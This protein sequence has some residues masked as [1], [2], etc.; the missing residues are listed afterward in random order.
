MR[1]LFRVLSDSMS[2]RHSRKSMP[3]KDHLQEYL[4]SIFPSMDQLSSST[5]L[6]M[7]FCITLR[8]MER[9]KNQAWRNT[10]T[11][12]GLLGISHSDGQ[13]KEYGRLVQAEMISTQSIGHLQEMVRTSTTIN[14]FQFDK[15][16][17]SSYWFVFVFFSHCDSWWFQ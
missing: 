8:Q 6:H 15:I 1:R 13:H 12:N 10:K 4:R 3:P 9:K 7:R 16:F 11:K 2:N 5:I 14:R 17:Y